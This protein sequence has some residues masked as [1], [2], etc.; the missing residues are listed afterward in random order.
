MC[1]ICTLHDAK[2]YLIKFGIT[3]HPFKT[4]STVLITLS[5]RLQYIINKFYSK[6]TYFST[7]LMVSSEEVEMLAR[8]SEGRKMYSK[9]MAWGISKTWR[10]RLWYIIQ[11]INYVNCDSDEEMKWKAGNQS[12]S[13]TAANES[14][15][16][17]S[18]E[19]VKL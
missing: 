7:L 12:I 1:T 3:T 10:Q 11:I 8:V 17:D 5:S 13:R 4:S 18:K 19:Y 14:T 15:N 16:W 2:I 6:N 9:L